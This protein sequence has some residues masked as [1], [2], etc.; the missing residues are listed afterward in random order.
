MPRPELV[1]PDLAALA[2][3]GD[4]EFKARFGDTPLSRA[5]LAGLQR[6]AATVLHNASNSRL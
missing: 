4:V 6:N 5:K 3:I 2:T 1:T